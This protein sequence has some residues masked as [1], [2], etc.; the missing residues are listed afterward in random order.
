MAT[1][2]TNLLRL[3]D[4][5]PDYITVAD[6]SGQ[7]VLLFQPV[8]LDYDLWLVVKRGSVRIASDI[9]ITDIPTSS[10]S[11]LSSGKIIE[12]MN[13]TDDFEGTVFILSEKFQND[14]GLSELMSLK[15]RFNLAP[16]VLL[17]GQSMEALEDFHRMAAR[18]ISLHDNP[19]RWES[20]RNLTKA[21]YYGG[22]YYFFQGENRPYSDD[23]TLTRF[24]TLAE[25]YA[26][27]ERET[28]FYADRL[29]LTS[30]YLSRLVKE[31]TGRTA[32]EIILNYVSL[33]ART[34]LLGTDLSIQQIS[35]ALHF[36]SQS[37]FGKF[38][39]KANGLSPREYRNHHVI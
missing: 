14:L 32:K 27:S 1:S 23:S 4:F 19:H 18:I 11:V 5:S 22:G 25:K 28:F 9:V 35:D 29:C 38:F 16:T 6:I 17:E 12:V 34:M 10:F 20:L 13:I 36:P 30:K 15:L 39:K 33:Q 26:S 3:K 2:T 8:R 37:V 24:L 21:F 7:D 31:K